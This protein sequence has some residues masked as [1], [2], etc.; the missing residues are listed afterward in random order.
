M[1]GA[2]EAAEAPGRQA[3]LLAPVNGS[4]PIREGRL[5]EGE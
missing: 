4:A 1:E 3:Q 2:V 5:V